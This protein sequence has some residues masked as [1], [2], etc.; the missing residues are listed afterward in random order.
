MKQV[1][2]R[3]SV[4]GVAHTDCQQTACIAV[5]QLSAGRIVPISAPF[6]Q[7]MFLHW[8]YQFTYINA[9]GAKRLHGVK[10]FYFACSI[11]PCR[12]F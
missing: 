11:S 4:S 10:F 12:T 1:F 3:G 5:V 2:G 6:G 7:Y 8:H 9:A